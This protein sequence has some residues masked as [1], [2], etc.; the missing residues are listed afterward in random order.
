VALLK[1]ALA[2]GV[3]HHHHAEPD[4]AHLDFEIG[5]DAPERVYPAVLAAAR[6]AAAAHAGWGAAAAAAA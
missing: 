3:L 5:A 2:P 6:R 4:Y 1:A